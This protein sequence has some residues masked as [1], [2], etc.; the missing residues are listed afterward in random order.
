MYDMTDDFRG[1]LAM[2]TSIGNNIGKAIAGYQNHVAEGKV[3]NIMSNPDLS[4]EQRLEQV[5]QVKDYAS[6]EAFKQLRAEQARQKARQQEVAAYQASPKYAFDQARNFPV[7]SQARTDLLRRGAERLGLGQVSEGY[8]GKPVTEADRIKSDYMN[9]ITDKMKN[10]QSGTTTTRSVGRATGG[11]Q[12]RARNTSNGDDFSSVSLKHNDDLLKAYKQIGDINKKITAIKGDV[13][14]ET[15]KL[16][17]DSA[18]TL[19]SLVKQKD[20]L[21]DNINIYNSNYESQLPVKREKGKI[22]LN[23]KIEDDLK[24]VL[25]GKSSNPDNTAYKLSLSYSVDSASDRDNISKI[26]K[27]GTDADI[28]EMIARLASQ[29]R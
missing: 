10:N 15:G 18:M 1:E 11:K 28:K 21:N 8:V 2:A 5:R 14:P 19:A 7:G 17:R 6:T 23:K 29:R 13:D 22:N 20:L 25:K 16:D 3:V 4:P 27:Y 12:S 9:A 26:L 24:W